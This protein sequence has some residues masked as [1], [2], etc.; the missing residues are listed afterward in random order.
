MS[1]RDAIDP[2]QLRRVLVIK[3]RHHGD[4]LLASPVLAA[5]KS[6]APQADIDA[7]VYDDTAA[8]L[9]GHPALD[10]LH[11]LPRSMRKA[12]LGKRLVSES[13]LLRMLRGRGY[14]LLVH[15]TDH[16]RGAWL[17][18]VLRPRWSVAHERAGTPWW[19]TGSFTHLAPQPRGTPRPTVERNLDAL[20]RLGIHP[21]AADRK[22]RLYTEPATMDSALAKL[23]AAGWTGEPYAVVHPGS[24]WLFKAWNAPGNARVL[25]H[26]AARGLL[27]VMTGAPDARERAI[28]DAVLHDTRARCI[29]LRGVLDLS[30]LGAV[31]R[32]ASFFFGVDSVPMHIAAAVDTPGAALFGPSDERVWGPWSPSIGVVASREFPCRP[33]GIDGCGGSKRSECLETLPVPQVL[34]TI[35]AVLER[36][37]R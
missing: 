14:D 1:L 2:G 25:E 12:G 32:R 34:A 10:Q 22:P 4:V 30:E 6:A 8:M 29:D 27:P 5:L 18:R 26:L 23:R 17:S 13:T 15:L 37:G 7:L 9:R 33:C 3:L 19:W 35:D 31:I 24:R 28:G 36:H 11:L 20:R 16:P 21:Q